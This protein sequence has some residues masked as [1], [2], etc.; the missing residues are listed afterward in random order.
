MHAVIARTEIK[1]AGM[2]IESAGML[3]LREV[4]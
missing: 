3:V 4:M 2:K 1:S